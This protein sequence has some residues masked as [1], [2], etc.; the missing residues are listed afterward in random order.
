[1][2]KIIVM[3]GLP[4][5]LW[6]HGNQHALAGKSEIAY[7]IFK[8]ISDFPTIHPLVVHF[9]L[10]L[11]LV[12]FILQ[13]LNLYLKKREF[14]LVIVAILSAA[15]IS[16]LIA[17]F[18]VHPHTQ[19]LAPHVQAVLQYHEFTAYLATG[20]SIVSLFFMLT[21]IKLKNEFTNLKY[22]ITLVIFLAVASV[23]L[24]GHLG[25]QLVHLEGIGV[26]GEY[27][28]QHQH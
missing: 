4:I 28:L 14:S 18:V 27:L 17:S 9:P 26:K 12:A 13:V 8:G 25:A 19:N 22:V 24:A 15:A 10:V 3:A 1:M 7:P 2:K 23:S 6:A 20:L 11:I 5:S 16:A 21:C